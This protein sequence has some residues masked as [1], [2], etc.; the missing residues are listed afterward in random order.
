MGRRTNLRLDD[1]VASPRPRLRAA[2]RRIRCHDPYR[3]RSPSHKAH[4]SLRP[5]SKRTLR[6]V[7]LKCTFDGRAGLRALFGRLVHHRRRRTMLLGQHRLRLGI[8]HR[9]AL[10][11]RALEGEPHGDAAAMALRVLLD[12]PLQ[13]TRRIL[14]PR[15]DVVAWLLDVLELEP[16]IDAGALDDVRAEHLGLALA[17]SQYLDPRRFRPPEHIRITEEQAGEEER[18][19]AAHRDAA[20]PAAEG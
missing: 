10:V 6:G 8:E 3:P 18:E 19:E 15:Q 16:E 14:L 12:R 5:F 2:H 1:T 9:V 13:V 17:R 20:P 4:R 7:R 11:P